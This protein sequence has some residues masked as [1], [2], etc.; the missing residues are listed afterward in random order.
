M[1]NSEFHDFFVRKVLRARSDEPNGLGPVQTRKW[2]AK[3]ATGIGKPHVTVQLH[4]GC[5]RGHS[6]E[7][8]FS[9]R[10]LESA[11]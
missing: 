8:G 2:G 6:L 9:F 3:A 1:L 11:L 7:S 10:G 4:A 5:L